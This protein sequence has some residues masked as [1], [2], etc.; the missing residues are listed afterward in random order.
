MYDVNDTGVLVSAILKDPVGKNGKYIAGAA[1]HDAPQKLLDGLQKV[2]GLGDKLKLNMVSQE[3]F[4][5]MGFPGAEELAQMFGWFN[6][7]TYFGNEIDR[8]SGQ[9]LAS[10]KK[11]DEWAKPKQ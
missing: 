2:T 9:Q 3:A 4:T 10:L 11:F 8:N 7:F 5:K 1:F 6:E